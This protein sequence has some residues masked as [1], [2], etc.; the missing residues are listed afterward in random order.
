[1]YL[2]LFMFMFIRMNIKMEMNM[3]METDTV[4]DMDTVM[5]IK[6]F[7]VGYW[8]LVKSLNRYPTSCRILPALFSLISDIQFSDSV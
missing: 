3:N 1:M 5:A 6:A 4:R 2:V 8:I 7:D